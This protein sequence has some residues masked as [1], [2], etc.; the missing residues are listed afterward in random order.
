[1]A[2]PTTM[3]APPT[4][5]LVALDLLRGLAALA[6]V[7][8]HFPWP[9]DVVAF[10]PRDYL[11]VDLFFV[12][13]GFVLARA[14]W[15]RLSEGQG[16]GRFLIDRLIRLYPLYLLATLF[17]AAI[18]LVNGAQAGTWAVTL[19]ANLLFLPA[20][21]DPAT[22]PNLFPFVYPAW[23]LFWE[24]LANLLLALVAFRLR[25]PLLPALLLTGALLL[26][27]TVQELGSLDAGP[28]WSDFVGGG[29]RV[30]Y[31]FF[32]GV[33]LALLHR[34]LPVRVALP[35]WLIGLALLAAFAPGT[36]LAFGAAY[37]FLAAILLFPLL[38]LLGAN[39]RTTP[40]SR[41]IGAGLGGVSYGIYVL[42]QPVIQLAAMIFSAE[43]IGASGVPGMVALVL[44]T[45]AAAW[46]ATRWIDT[47][48]RTW[49]RRR[50]RVQ[51]GSAMPILT[52]S[53]P[54]A[55]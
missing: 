31:G 39:A 40:L 20:P 2:R 1:M 8:R 54:A 48:L 14:W 26:A 15:P 37:D 6:I 43:R 55:P 21:P 11:A 22:G 27:C 24:L 5:R 10:L 3:D 41:R 45:L 28:R 32:A 17:A 50:L 18:A 34:R 35:D 33:A 29:F 44:V 23:S 4:D 16:R 30:L 47:P 49:T 38:V 19:G 46:A 52:T 51:R 7:T 9:G 36:A 25:G 42:H 13:S 53:S 12:L